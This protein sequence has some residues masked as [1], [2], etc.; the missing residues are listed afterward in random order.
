[1]TAG[2]LALGGIDRDVLG[3]LERSDARARGDGGSGA[4][5]L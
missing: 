5:G 4:A 2:R 1:M 3:G